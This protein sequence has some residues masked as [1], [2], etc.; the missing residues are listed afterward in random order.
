M[1]EDSLYPLDTFYR[2]EKRYLYVHGWLSALGALA[3]LRPSFLLASSPQLPR[4]HVT[5]THEKER[6][7]CLYYKQKL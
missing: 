7:P 2:Q 6:P 3:R 4:G 1:W 5:D